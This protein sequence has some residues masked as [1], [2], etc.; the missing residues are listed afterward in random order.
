MSV[1]IKYEIIYLVSYFD[2]YK[3]LENESILIC[4]LSL[5]PLIDVANFSCC[6]KLKY[7]CIK[8]YANCCEAMHGADREPNKCSVESIVYR[9]L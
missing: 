7:F 8:L 6:S 2:K 9:A 3:K 4:Y 1:I 5:R